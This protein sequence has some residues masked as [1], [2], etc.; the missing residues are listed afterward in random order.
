MKRPGPVRL[1]EN[2]RLQIA[3]LEIALSP[4]LA[5]SA[6]GP[7]NRG[8]RMD[9]PLLLWAGWTMAALAV[10]ALGAGMWNLQRSL[11][12]S[13]AKAHPGSAQGEDSPTG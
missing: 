7:L 5:C 2:P 1:V 12:R 13:L 9:E 4:M 6:I 8:H 11:R 3:I 10:V